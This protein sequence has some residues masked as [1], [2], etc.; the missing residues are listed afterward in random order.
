M[1]LIIFSSPDCA[2]HVSSCGHAMHSTCYQKFFQSL[3]S[4]ERERINGFGFNRINNFDVSTGEFLCP[5]CERLSN[6]ILPMFP[7]ITNLRKKHPSAP[8]AEISLNTF[9]NGLRSSVE[10]WYLKEDK[11]NGPALHRMALKATFEEVAKLQGPDFLQYLRQ[12]TTTAQAGESG[13]FEGNMTAMMNVFSM[14]TFTSSL[15]LDPY[16]EDY[17]VPLLCLQSAA[18]TLISLERMLWYEDKPLFGGL[19]PREEDTVRNITRYIAVF[20]SSYNKPQHVNMRDLVKKMKNFVKLQCLQSNAMF[21]L[22][23]LLCKVT[24]DDTD[25]L[26][27]DAFG[28]LVSLLVSLPCLFNSETPPRLPTGQ[29]TEIHCLKLCLLLHIIQVT[30]SLQPEDLSL[31]MQSPGRKQENKT[32]DI[33]STVW[34]KKGI[35][36][37]RSEL[38][39]SKFCSK[40]EEMVL[41]YLRCCALMFQHFTDVFPGKVLTSDGGMSYSPLARYLGLPPT[42][43]Q[44][45]DNPASGAIMSS[46]L[47]K[48][49]SQTN[50]AGVGRFPLNYRRVTGPS[51]GC[52]LLYPLTSL[53]SDP[54]WRGG[55]IPLPRDYTDLMN[56]AASFRCGNSVAGESKTP[57]LCLV[58]GALVCS[59]SH[60][61]ET[62]ISTYKC[63]GCTSHAARCAA[64][65]G[66]FLRIRECFIVIHNKITRGWSSA[67]PANIDNNTATLSGA[68]LPAPYVDEYGETDKGLRRGNPLMLDEE[69]YAELNR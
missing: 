43:E 66:V 36:V 31:F 39:I 51:A 3:E 18:F 56:L 9:I 7:S 24:P 53:T 8:V 50:P 22:S 33:L 46:I 42:L 65:S 10:S 25:P 69:K 54:D 14:S 58:C 55:L 13:I 37:G 11:E 45:L 60:C 19:N 44:F 23:T 4:K 32:F 12:N 20:P 29:G 52:R 62:T 16:E 48:E 26:T 64:G 17:R 67:Y 2:P 59:Y 15:E 1:F 30:S 6:T 5:I 68:Y 61:C 34:K 38:N 63:G 21:I 35:K 28:V 57:V 41:P 27:F 40:L 49:I 47:E